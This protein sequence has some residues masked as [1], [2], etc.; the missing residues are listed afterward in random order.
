MR[1][2]Q[3]EGSYEEL[4]LESRHMDVHWVFVHSHKTC[5]HRQVTAPLHAKADI[6]NSSGCRLEIAPLVSQGIIA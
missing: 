1:A 6:T 3:K 5:L 2:G 4:E